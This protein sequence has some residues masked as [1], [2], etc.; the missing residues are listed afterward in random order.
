MA[1]PDVRR[2]GVDL[3]DRGPI[4]IKLRPGEIGAEQE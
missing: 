4:R 1:A 3:K 2:I